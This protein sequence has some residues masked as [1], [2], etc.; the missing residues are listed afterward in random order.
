MNSQNALHTISHNIANKNTEGYSRQQTETFTNFPYGAGKTRIGTGAR[1]A[2]VQRVNNAYMERQ[3]AEEKSNLGFMKGQA[4]SLMRLEQVYNEEAVEGI[5]ASMVKFFNSFRE[6]STSPESVPKRIAVKES[7]DLLAR[8]FN[9]VAQQLHDIRGDA[10]Q[11]MAITVKD[12][13][14]NTQ[15]IASLNSQI[16]KIEVG[17]GYANDERDRRDQLIKELGEKI[18]IKWTEGEDSTVTIQTGG[19]AILVAGNDA[20]RLAA[21]PM[22]GTEGKAEGDFDIMY[23]H[24]EYAEPLAI[25][26]R[27]N[28]G[29]LGGLIKVRDHDVRE[30]Q[31]KM[32]FLASEIS[33]S[34]NDVHSQGYNTFN[35]TGVNLFDPI[36]EKDGAEN[37]KVSAEVMGDVGRIAAGLD[38]NAPGDNR[39]ANMIS[40]IQNEKK[41]VDG[42]T[43]LDEYYNGIVA[44]M[45][46]RTE[47]ANHMLETQQ[48]VVTQLENLRESYSG[49]NIDQEVANMV[50]W[51]K[52]F[53]ASARIIR[54]ADEMLDTVINL[55]RY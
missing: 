54:T 21:V 48:G 7:A 28:G 20:S 36:S 3:L 37:M 26:E 44:E 15:E 6:L 33:N 35:Q 13:N 9:K 24:H 51:Q 52:Q 43:S 34:V 49:V 32:N 30:F 41:F 11:Q 46:L 23:Y 53:D 31:D 40:D 14:S 12:I 47:K 22:P 17:G 27:I 8:D 19:N 2:S 25:T 42:T 29:S 1:T 10:N 45:G 18:D 38:P 5:N 4:N 55:R 16:Q 50:E 39:V